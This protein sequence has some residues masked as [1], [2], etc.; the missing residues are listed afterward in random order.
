MGVVSYSDLSAELRWDFALGVTEAL[1]REYKTP[2]GFSFGTPRVAAVLLSENP[3][4]EIVA[5]DPRRLKA[6]ARMK[7]AYH[8]GIVEKYRKAYLRGADFP[9]IVI[10][11]SLRNMLCEGAHR[12]CAAERAGVKEIG[13]LDVA[14][15]ALD[16]IIQRGA[17]LLFP[18]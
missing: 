4:I 13:A 14:S 11:S 6:C 5:V 16:V 18:R 3:E 10:N 15:I 2:K 8:T 12:A 1:E 17:A 7:G 9:P